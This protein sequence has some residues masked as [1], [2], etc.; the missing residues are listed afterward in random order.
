MTKPKTCIILWMQCMKK[1]IRN[2]WIP[3]ATCQQATIC[4]VC[5][6]LII[7]MIGI[8]CG[9][10][11]QTGRKPEGSHRPPDQPRQVDPSHWIP[12]GCMPDVS[13]N[14]N[15]FLLFSAYICDVEIKIVV[16]T[17]LWNEKSS[18]LMTNYCSRLVWRRLPSDLTSS[19][20]WMVRILHSAR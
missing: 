3:L 20:K 11:I 13:H 2:N 8:L 12:E 16:L 14:H 7:F 1:K 10:T 18:D 9:Y 6:F 5:F 15:I 17:V 4:L 19:V